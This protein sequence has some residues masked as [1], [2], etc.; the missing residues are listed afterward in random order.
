[1]ARAFFRGGVRDSSF[2]APFKTQVKERTSDFAPRELIGFLRLVVGLDCCDH[3]LFAA[4]VDYVKTRS[5]EFDPKYVSTALW[6]FASGR[7]RDES[8]IKALVDRSLE[9]IDEMSPQSVSNIAWALATLVYHDNTFLEALC[10][11]YERFPAMFSLQERSNLGWA[12]GVLNPELVLRVIAP[13]DLLDDELPDIDWLQRYQALL[14]AGAISP[15]THALRS[16]LIFDRFV[17]TP[18][19]HFEEEVE[20]SL[21]EVLANHTFSL[22]YGQIVGGAVVD[23]LLDFDGRRIIIECDGSLHHLLTGPD[24][25][26]EPGRDIIQERICVSLGYEVV[27]ITTRDWWAAS[28][29]AALIRERLGL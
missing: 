1:M 19:S 16:E 3:E 27:H 23:W 21:R 18:I 4:S 6:I 15:G 22:R 14:V 29:K 7:Y 11:R 28:D 20:S 2:F 13:E 24:G 8:S 10:A 12:C 25:G 26:R 17:N 5:S 9:V